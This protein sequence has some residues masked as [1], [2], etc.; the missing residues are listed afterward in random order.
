MEQGGSSGSHFHKL[1]GRALTDHEFREALLDTEQ[2]AGAL[3][4]MG[5]E[6]TED[7][8]QALNGAIEAL[9]NLAQSETL[10]GDINAVA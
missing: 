2:Q 5:I 1:L 6:P 10:G 9:N 8:L 4:S 3:E 7:V